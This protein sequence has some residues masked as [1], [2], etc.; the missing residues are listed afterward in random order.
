MSETEI[1][2]AKIDARTHEGR[3]G[4]AHFKAVKISCTDSGV[5]GGPL[6]EK[7]NQPGYHRADKGPNATDKSIH[8]C[9]SDK[10]PSLTL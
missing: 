10:C 3:A 6:V 9:K 5:S 8:H 7:N 2:D 1:L 4:P